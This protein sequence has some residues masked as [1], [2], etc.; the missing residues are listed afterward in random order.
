METYSGMISSIVK[1]GPP[2]RLLPSFQSHLMVREMLATQRPT[3]KRWLERGEVRLLLS[4][5]RVWTRVEEAGGVTHVTTWSRPPRPSTGPTHTSSPTISDRQQ[6]LMS[7]SR[8]SFPW[9]GLVTNLF[10]RLL[11]ANKKSLMC[12]GG[13]YSLVPI[14]RHVLI[15][16]HA[17][18]H[19]TSH[20]P[21]KRHAYKGICNRC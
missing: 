2:C 19:W 9:T 5:Q 6:T 16:R 7:L 8:P 13:K 11:F 20:G 10:F 17:S 4:P 12:L 18:R 3:Y 1:T 14:K 21:I 15:N